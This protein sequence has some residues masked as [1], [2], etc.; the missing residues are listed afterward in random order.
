VS[1]LS[2]Q[3]SLD[4]LLAG[5]GA[6]GRRFVRLFNPTAA[7]M[8]VVAPVLMSIP[9]SKSGAARSS[10]W[11]S[12]DA[13]GRRFATQALASD[14]PGRG[15]LLVRATVP[16]LGYATVELRDDAE[17]TE[18]PVKTTTDG[19]TVVM[20]SDRY[21]IEF[22]PARGGTIRSLVAKSLG[23]REF[24][25]MVHGRRFNELRGHFYDQGAF[26]SSADL[27]AE[28]R[29]VEDGP[30]R[31]TAEVVGTIAGHPFVQRVSIA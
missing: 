30:L 9:I 1:D 19:H 25:D 23:G 22:D 2:V 20:E 11:V 21:R 13:E 3:R 12:L 24:V 26:Q 17:P 28:V 31:A 4:A 14:T 10:R 8:D 15:L 5:G 27:P 29:I 6:R 16:P 18:A 7:A